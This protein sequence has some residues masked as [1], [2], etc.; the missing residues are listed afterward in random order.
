MLKLN[1]KLK[2]LISVSGVFALVGVTYLVVAL[3]KNV[4]PE[5]GVRNSTD[6][7]GN[8]VLLSKAEFEDD[9]LDNDW[10]SKE[11]EP[12]FLNEKAYF[13]EDGQ[14]IVS[15]SLNNRFTKYV[16]FHVSSIN[17]G[18]DAAFKLEGFDKNNN[19]LETIIID[20]VMTTKVYANRFSYDYVFIDR[21][22]I[23]YLGQEAVVAV[24]YVSIYALQ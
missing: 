12:I 19:L 18:Q 11:N 17:N 15:P 16:E 5:P 14:N 4:L 21:V 24:D 9:D 6:E 20:G 22:V 10:S 2:F 1:S 13:E 3:L 23:T 7:Y 8:R